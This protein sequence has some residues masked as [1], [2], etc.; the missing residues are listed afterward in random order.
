MSVNLL[1]RHVRGVNSVLLPVSIVLGGKCIRVSSLGHP[2]LAGHV[3]DADLLQ[4]LAVPRPG[5][6]RHD[7]S[8]WEAVR[9]EGEM[10]LSDLTV[11]W[12]GVSHLGMV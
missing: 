6:T 2:Y 8:D 3:G 7:S 12:S 5:V 11:E 4:E 10:R 9:P 1:N